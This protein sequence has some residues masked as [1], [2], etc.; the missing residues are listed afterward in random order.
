MSE[1]RI[2]EMTLL[3]KAFAQVEQLPRKEQAAFARWIISELKDEEKWAKVFA[4]SQS[5]L[6]YLADEALDE[7]RQGKTTP[8]DF[9]NL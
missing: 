1:E 9:D 3:E 5:T 2:R 7:F 4:R 6:A 8:V